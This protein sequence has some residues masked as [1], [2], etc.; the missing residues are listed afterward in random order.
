MR[1]CVICDA[2]T[3]GGGGGG[4]GGPSKEQP[5]SS[6]GGGG[7]GRRQKAATSD[8]QLAKELHGKCAKESG[9][10]K[11]VVGCHHPIYI[12]CTSLP[13]GVS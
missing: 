7:G 4:T 3:E 9:M 1:S 6:R 12:D 5:S 13:G 2:A 8:W 11:G 10:R